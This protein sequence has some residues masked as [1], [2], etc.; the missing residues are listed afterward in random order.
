MD[1]QTFAG[2]ESLHGLKYQ[3]AVLPNR[4]VLVWGPWW[5]VFHNATMFSLSGL[6]Q[7]SEDISA[8]LGTDYS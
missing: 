6:L 2:K 4:M 8:R 3:G 1:F 7:D 5:G